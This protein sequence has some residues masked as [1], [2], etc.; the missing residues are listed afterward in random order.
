MSYFGSNC[1][2]ERR[3]VGALL[4]LLTA[5]PLFSAAP[6]KAQLFEFFPYSGYERAYPRVHH[7]GKHRKVRHKDSE[8]IKLEKQKIPRGP[9][10]VVVAIGRQRAYLYSDG[11][12]IADGAIS[13]GVPGHPTPLGVFSVIAKSRYHRSN[14]YS[15]APMP[16]MQRITWSGIA[17][18][19]GPLPGYPASHGCIRLTQSF[20]VKLWSIAKVGARVIVT[21]NEVAPVAFDSDRLFEPKKPEEQRPAEKQADATPGPVQ[22][23]ARTAFA[24]NVAA[25]A[26]AKQPAAVAPAVVPDVAPKD[27]P[28]DAAKQAPKPKGPVEVFV[29]RKSAKV[30]VKQGFT[31]MFEAPVTIADPGQPWGTHVFTVMDIKDGKAS[32][33]VMSVPSTYARAV[34]R[35]ERRGSKGSKRERAAAKERER[36]EQRAAELAGVPTPAEALAHFQLPPDAIQ[37]ISELLT[38]GSS[39]IVSDNKLSDE[40]GPDTGF[41]VS[42]R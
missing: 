32:W 42:T 30:Y 27:A 40:T 5:L 8:N 19:E 3:V 11:V 25:P 18:H 38:P 20:A 7:T 36:Q 17:L 31:S 12:R 14:I 21:R 16:Y 24:E 4:C 6:A 9:V 41:I 29:S 22:M 33:N 35:H 26:D 34:S 13:T 37:R 15:G 2:F 28:K 39:M 23:A 10:Q 1:L